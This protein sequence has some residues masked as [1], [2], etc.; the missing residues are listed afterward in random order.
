LPDC[1]HTAYA[2]TFDV[3]LK[4]TMIQDNGFENETIPERQELPEQGEGYH[5]E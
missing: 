3:T 2:A 5:I 4:S 1:S